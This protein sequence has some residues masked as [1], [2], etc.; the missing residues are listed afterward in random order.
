M[1]CLSPRGARAAASLARGLACWGTLGTVTG[2]TVCGASVRL[3]S[4][5]VMRLNK[6]WWV[7][8]AQHRTVQER[9]RF[10]AHRS[11]WWKL[12]SGRLQ[13]GI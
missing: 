1:P 10:A 11:A 2:R 7:S 5:E 9:M 8:A 3:T 4:A 12:L 6:T 13:P